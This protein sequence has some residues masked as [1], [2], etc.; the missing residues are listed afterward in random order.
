MGNYYSAIP[1]KRIVYDSATVSVNT[2]NWVTYVTDMPADITTVEFF[3]STGQLL[4]I[5]TG[6]GTT[7]VTAIPYYITPGGVSGQVGFHINDGMNLFIRAVDGN[8][9]LGLVVANFLR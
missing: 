1:I 2:T 8:A 9:T 6:T 4:E 5:G 7:A 3:N